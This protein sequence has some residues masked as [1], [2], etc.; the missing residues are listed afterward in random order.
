MKRGLEGIKGLRWKKIKQED[1]VVKIG[2]TSFGYRSI[3]FSRTDRVQVGFE[4]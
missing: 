4:I 2:L 1:E 3:L